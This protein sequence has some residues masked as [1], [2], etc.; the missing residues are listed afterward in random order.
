M[1]KSGCVKDALD[2]M[3]AEPNKMKFICSK[4]ENAVDDTKTEY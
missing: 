1:K 3:A 2:L 4:H